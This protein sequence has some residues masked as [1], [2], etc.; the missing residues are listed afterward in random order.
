MDIELQSLK[1]NHLIGD[2]LKLVALLPSNIRYRYIDYLFENVKWIGTLNYRIID[3]A[4]SIRDDETSIYILGKI[5]SL[6]YEV[7][8]IIKRGGLRGRDLTIKALAKKHH[9]HY[10]TS[11][12]D[13]VDIVRKL[14]GKSKAIICMVCEDLDP[15]MIIRRGL[16]PIGLGMSGYVLSSYLLGMDRRLV[17]FLRMGSSYDGTSYDVKIEKTLTWSYTS[18]SKLIQEGII[19]PTSIKL[20]LQH[21]MEYVYPNSKRPLND[22]YMYQTSLSHKVSKRSIEPVPNTMFYRVTLGT[23]IQSM[24][25]SSG[26]SSMDKSSGGSSM[27]CLPVTR[28]ASGMRRS[29]FYHEEEE[30]KE[31]VTYCGTFYYLEPDSTTF[32]AFNPNRVLIASNKIDAMRRLDV[33]P[34]IDENIDIM[35]MWIDGE[36]PS[37]LMM[38]PREYIDAMLK[39]G[40]IDDSYMILS[41][42]HLDMLPQ[43]KVYCAH[44]LEL[45]A[46]EDIYDQPLCN[47]A[48]E[49]GY[50]IVVLTGMV[51]SH[52][53][54]SEILDTRHRDDSF[55][56]LIYTQ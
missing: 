2:D 51:G 15:L 45:Y 30:E 12:N 17:Q 43:T 37:D 28:Y 23:D 56:S 48:A 18:K 20:I 36:L 40:L 16:Y 6:E 10:P 42:G 5:S 8:N 46:S 54:V 25:K 21:G 27:H 53:V 32:L 29:L 9:I 26:G 7:N 47:L 35:D 3:A 31:D 4:L 34:D 33:E 49:K 13:I 14:S 19:E 1:N 55:S 24:D 22:M 11:E 50:D 38:T 52:Q 39:H 44:L 41:G